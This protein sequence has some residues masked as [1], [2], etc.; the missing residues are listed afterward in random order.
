MGTDESFAQYW[1]IRALRRTQEEN[2]LAIAASEKTQLERLLAD[3]PAG[4]DRAYELTQ[5]LGTIV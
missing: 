4:T 3:L 1:A 5:L 2:P